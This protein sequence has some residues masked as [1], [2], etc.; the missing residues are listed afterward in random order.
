MAKFIVCAALSDYH[1]DTNLDSGVPESVEGFPLM[2]TVQAQM[3][4]ITVSTPNSRL[5][6]LPGGLY[7]R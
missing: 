2:A 1:T 6:D 5:L 4:Q 7:L 3:Q